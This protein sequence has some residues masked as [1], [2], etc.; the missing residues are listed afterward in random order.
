M[1]P[2]QCRSQQRLQRPNGSHVTRRES[3]SP[4]TAPKA[5]CPLTCSSLT[6]SCSHGL[7]TLPGQPAASAPA[8][9]LPGTPSLVHSLASA[10][11]STL[12]G[13]FLL[14]KAFPTTRSG[15]RPALPTALLLPSSSSS[16]PSPKHGFI[17]SACCLPLR[18]PSAQ[19]VLHSLA[20]PAALEL[21]LRHAAHLASR[22]SAHPWEDSRILMAALKSCNFQGQKQTEATRPPFTD[23][24]TEAG[25]VG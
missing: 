13:H 16:S 5:L 2:W 14:S 1:G 15:P 22:V 4:A 3:P 21:F 20:L 8:G 19:C 24:E 23:E 12:K 17:C 10:L 25:E 18:Q 6:R 11:T 7:P 9:P